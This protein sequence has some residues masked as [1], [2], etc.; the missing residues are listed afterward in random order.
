MIISVANIF[1]FHITMIS[2]HLYRLQYNYQLSTINCQL[3]Y[4]HVEDAL[5]QW[6]KVNFSPN[7][8][9]LANIC[10]GDKTIVL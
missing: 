9:I 1:G 10:P 2:E 7:G 4:T 5:R 6:P 3:L 8:T